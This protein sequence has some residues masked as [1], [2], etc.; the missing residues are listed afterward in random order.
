M[1]TQHTYAAGGSYTVVLSVSKQ[2]PSCTFGLCTAEKSSV[3]A[4]R[5]RRHRPRRRRRRRRT[6]LCEPDADTF[7]ALNG[8]FKIEVTWE[9]K[10]GETG[11]GRVVPSATSDNTGIFYFFDD[12]NWELL[13]KVLDGC[14]IN[15]HFWVFG[16][17]ATNVKYQIRVTDLVTD[18]VWIY[19]NPQGQ[20]S[21][22]ITDTSAFNTCTVDRSLMRENARAARA[23]RAASTLRR[24]TGAP[25]PTADADA[26]A[27]PDAQ[28]DVG[29][30]DPTQHHAVRDLG[31]VPG[32]A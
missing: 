13:L 22:A 10:N 29:P 5:R 6:A 18:D 21:E 12:Q 11:V 3:V 15:H 25:T 8:D 27:E 30:C 26:D 28:A 7:C 24:N 14:T 2:D 1:T 4:G 19:D 23:A 31:A 9:K 17:A 20:S 32:Q 16:G